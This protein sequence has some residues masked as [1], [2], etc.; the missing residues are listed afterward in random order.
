MKTITIIIIGLLVLSILIFSGYYLDKRDK[1]VNF[2]GV[3]IKS[4]QLKDLT[5]PIDEGPFVLCSIK[6]DKCAVSVK[7]GLE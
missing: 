6:D 5:E 3:E 4:S 7:R 1:E 2:G